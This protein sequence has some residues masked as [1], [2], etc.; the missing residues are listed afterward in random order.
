MGIEQSAVNDNVSLECLGFD[1]LSLMELKSDIE[2]RI[3][4][5]LEND[6]DAKTTVSALQDLLV[7]DA[8]W[9]DRSHAEHHQAASTPSPLRPQNTAHY[10]K[11]KSEHLSPA[12]PG[13]RQSHDLV[14]IPYKTVNDLEILADVY[15]P[16][17]PTHSKPMAIGKAPNPAT[18]T[19]TDIGKHSADDTRRRLH[20]HVKNSDSSMANLAPS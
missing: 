18:D 16:K 3:P 9:Q 14:T 10:Q 11:Q 17:Q 5:Q 8:R 19:D 12:S 7:S 2:G 4:F 6:F 1:S 15:F 13:I 20:D